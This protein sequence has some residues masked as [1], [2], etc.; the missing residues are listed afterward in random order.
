M[1]I[2]GSG[3]RGKGG[4]I[5]LYSSPDLRHWTYLHPLIEGTFSG[6]DSTNPVDTGDMWECPD[7]FPIGNKHVLPHLHDGQGPLESWHLRESEIHARK[8]RRR[9]LG[10]LLCR[11][12]NARS[13]WPTHLVGMDYRIASRCRVNQS[14]M[15]WRNVTSTRVVS[16]S[17]QSTADRSR[18]RGEHA[19]WWANCRRS[20]QQTAGP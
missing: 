14:R 3:F 17:R 12:N 8:R 19:S 9:R 20:G 5:L 18:S 13:Q 4:T 2:L 6:K 7:F 15:G 16:I 10:I 11:K 1:L